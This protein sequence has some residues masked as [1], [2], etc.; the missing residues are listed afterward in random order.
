MRFPVV[1]GAILM[2]MS[3]TRAQQQFTIFASIVDVTGFPVET[4]EPG[5]LR[6]LENDAEAM[7]VKVE[8]IEWPTKLQI[9]VDNGTGLGGTNFIHLRNGLTKLI[10][11]M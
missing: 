8:P 1:L 10:E 4:L 3:V 5:D 6:L 11:A 2:A 7:V 9:L